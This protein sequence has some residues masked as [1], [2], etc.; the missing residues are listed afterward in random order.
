VTSDLERAWDREYRRGRYRDQAPVPFVQDIIAAAGSMKQGSGLGLYVGCGNGRNYVPLVEAGLDLVGLDVSGEAIAQLRERLPE[1]ADR[2]VHA[3]LRSL[4]L[5]PTFRIVI[6]IQVFQHGDRQEAHEHLARAQELLLPGGLFCLRVNAVGTNIWPEHEVVET[7]PDRGST[8]RYLAGPKAGLLVHFFS[9][10]ELDER[11]CPFFVRESVHAR[12]LRRRTDG[13]VGG[14]HGEDE[15][16][17]WSHGS[18]GSRR[19]LASTY[20][21]GMRPS[22]I[23]IPAMSGCVLNSTI[24]PSR[25]RAM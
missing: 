22:C 8:I 18:G 4:P 9:L 3:D 14:L 17:G 24:L 16:R 13:V 23:I 25:T 12:W 19:T 6:G 2:L 5:E 7:F 21:C 1:R 15:V 11:R 20:I 10:E